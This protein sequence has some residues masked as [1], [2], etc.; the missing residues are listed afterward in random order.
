MEGRKRSRSSSDPKE[1]K[2]A[3]RDDSGPQAS[4]DLPL[5]ISQKTPA[6]NGHSNTSTAANKGAEEMG[7]GSDAR[8]GPSDM[9]TPKMP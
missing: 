6:N 3:R 2:R 4:F 7:S 1:N 9:E 5:R 8:P